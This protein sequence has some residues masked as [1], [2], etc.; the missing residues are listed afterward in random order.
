MRRSCTTPLR[1]IRAKCIECAG[2][3]R[4]ATRC[5]N[6]GCPLYPYRTGRDPA[7]A[8]CGPA[9]SSESAKILR[10]HRGRAVSCEKRTT[11]D[12]KVSGKSP[13]P[14]GST[15]ETVLGQPRAKDGQVALSTMSPPKR[16][17]I[18]KAAEAFFREIQDEI[19]GPR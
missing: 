5:E 12:V 4:A 16:R 17:R 3:T 13:G 1:S 6:E 9:L 14:Q 8:G 7:R 18:M 2:S 15:P 11:Q 10:R 19:G